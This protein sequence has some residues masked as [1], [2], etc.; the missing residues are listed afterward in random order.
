MT[1]WHIVGV[2][3]QSLF[4][5]VVQSL[6]MRSSYLPASSA[7]A[8]TGAIVAVPF[9]TRVA[10][11]LEFVTLLVAVSGCQPQLRRRIG[12]CRL[13]KVCSAAMQAAATSFV[14]APEQPEWGRRI[15]DKV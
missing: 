15:P 1:W 9:T 6:G 4:G 13:P 8:M 12:T 10:R 14:R 11:L 3:F 7:S 5:Q 2:S